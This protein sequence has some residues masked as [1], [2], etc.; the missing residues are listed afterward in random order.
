MEN[1]LKTV[2]GND[3]PA[4]KEEIKEEIKEETETEEN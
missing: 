2:Y 4:E 1:L 3:K